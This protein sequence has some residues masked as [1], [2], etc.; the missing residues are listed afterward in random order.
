[1]K[2]AALFA[3]LLVQILIIVGFWGSYHVHHMMGNQLT[4]DWIGQS[5]AWGRLS[6]LLAAFGILMLLLLISR[7]TW[8]EGVFGMDRLARAHHIV[9]FALIL[10][11][12]IHPI[13]LTLGHSAQAGIGYLAQTRDFV[14]NWEDVFG[15]MLGMDLII[16]AMGLSVFV[17]L[18]KIR[19]ETWYYSHLFLYVAIALAFGHQI[20]V[21]SDFTE[22]R[23]FRIYWFVLYAFVAGV[24]VYSRFLTPLKY[25]FR[26]RFTVTRLVAETN[27]VTSV[28]IE[29]INLDQFPARAGQFMIVR[30]L[31]KG[32]WFEAHPFSISCLPDGKQLRL[33][34]KQLGDF[35]RK[36]PGLRSGT[37]I[38]IDG[39]HGIFTAAQSHSKKILMIAGGIGITPIRSV[40]EELIS[41]SRNVILIYGNRDTHSLVFK[42]ELDALT[43]KSDGRL[44]VIPVMSDDP[45]WPGEKGRVDRERIS[46]LVPDLSERDVFLC[47]PP[48]MMKSARKSLAELNIP[49]SRIHDE[50]FAL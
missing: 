49:S 47:G 38:L 13:L 15:A 41:A 40:A 31:A 37:P 19:Y 28:C 46:R 30:F 9:G 3:I 44:K 43:A 16:I 22:N 1:V 23:Y 27:E 25:Y 32:F 29:G 7:A 33:T 5:L 34:I 21:G 20:A 14:K 6:G 12:V 50:R 18:K 48:V 4:G 8:L 26:H 24:L 35:T 10:L 17:V 42:A 39:P 11:L 45:A 36:I 2:K